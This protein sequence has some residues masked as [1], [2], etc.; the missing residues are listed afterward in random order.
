LIASP[1]VMANLYRLRR[2]V[3]SDRLDNNASYLFDK[4]SFFA[5][6]VLNMA[7]PGGPKFELLYHDM[8]M[9]V[10][11]QNEFNDINKVIIQQQI[12]TEYRVAFPHLYNSLPR[13][14]HL[15]PYHH[16][17]ENELTAEGIAFWWAL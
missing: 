5:A 14:V 16:L 12:R 17:L 11:D 6:K 1:P 9:F 7:I 2:T 13:S 8:D 4:K 10:E 3:L 15:L